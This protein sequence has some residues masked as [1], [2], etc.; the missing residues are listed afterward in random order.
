MWVILIILLLVVLCNEGIKQTLWYENRF[1]DALKFRSSPQD[2]DIINIGSNSGKYGF[3]F[4]HSG[5][6]GMNYAV[7]PQTIAF[8]CRV[9]RRVIYHVKPG[10]WAIIPIVPFSS[11]L[12]EYRMRRAN[13]KYYLILPSK[14]IPSYSLKT[15]IRV[16]ISRWFPVL[17]WIR[18]PGFFR[19]LFIK[20]QF[21]GDLLDQNSMNM[22]KLQEDGHKWVEGWKKQFSI[23]ELDEPLSKEHNVIMNNNKAILSEMIDLCRKCSVIPVLVLPP[24]TES[25]LNYLTFEVR[26]RYIYDFINDVVKM[27]KVM[28]FDYT[29]KTE[30]LKPDLYFNSFFL[31]K[32]G[33]KLFTSHLIAQIR[34]S[35][36]NDDP[37]SQ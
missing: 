25:L 34:K 2:L 24:I 16:I 28:F 30:F 15:E 18:H 32:R 31:N 3:D 5:L 29:E 37:D 4:T 12:D 14:E 20:G 19:L 26:Q 6:K 9:L 7:G 35:G 21:Q 1:G 10:G 33:R 23:G 27:K 36:M 17:E 22:K 11:I 8:D 13:D